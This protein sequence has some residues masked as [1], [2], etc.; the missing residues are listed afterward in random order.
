MRSDNDE[1]AVVR[2][3]DDLDH[4]DDDDVEI[5]ADGHVIVRVGK[6]KIIATSCDASMIPH[7]L[8]LGIKTA[9]ELLEMQRGLDLDS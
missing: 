8:D 6:M 3:D 2:L 7:F 4:H 9:R 1:N 5:I